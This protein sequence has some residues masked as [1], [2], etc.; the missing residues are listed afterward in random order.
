MKTVKNN[1]IAYK[2]IDTL[3]MDKE[4]I[5]QYNELPSNLPETI[6]TKKQ[7]NLVEGLYYKYLAHKNTVGWGTDL[8]E[9]EKREKW[10]SGHRMKTYEAMRI[11]LNNLVHI[12]EKRELTST[13]AAD[14]FY[15][16]LT[17]RESYV[18]LLQKA[19]KKIN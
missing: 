13:Q 16:S 1:K 11:I 17:C 3:I 5:N 2:I 12:N 15:S 19:Y 6:L 18:A 7:K 14:T 8:Y 10:P 9:L 4:D